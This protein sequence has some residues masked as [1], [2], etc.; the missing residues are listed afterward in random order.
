M[1]LMTPIKN[2]LAVLIVIGAVVWALDVLQFF[3]LSVYKEQYMS[4]TLGLTLAVIYLPAE[5]DA[6]TGRTFGWWASIFAAIAGFTT[7]GYLAVMY[8]VL[9]PTM[10]VKPMPAIVCGTILIPLLVEALRRVA[11]LTL[12]LILATFL[13]IGVFA[14]YLPGY[15]EGRQV[16]PG[17]LIS[18]LTLDPN[19]IL[20]LPLLVTSTIVVSFVLFGNILNA[21]GGGA[22]FTDLSLAA[23][24]RFRGGTAKI[25]IAASA[26]FGSV[27]GSAIANVASTGVITIPMMKKSGYSPSEASAIEASASTGGQLLP[28]VMGAVAFLMAEFLNVPYAEVALAALIPGLLYYTCLFIQVD[29]LAARKGITALKREDIPR[30]SLV[31][32]K[33]GHYIIPFAVLVTGL[34]KYNLEAER[35]VA[36]AT[37][38][39]LVLGAIRS[40]GPTRLTFRGVF[41]ALVTGGRT[42]ADIIVI[43]ASAGAIIGVLNITA[44][45]FGITLQL[46]SIGESSLLLLLITA[47]LL[48]IIM[49]MGLPTLGV[50]LLLATLTAPSLVE[51]GLT[52]ISAHMFI[53]FFGMMS[54]IT[55]PIA[56]AA[57]AAA[58]IGGA[59]PM[60]VGW[61]A[62][63]FSWPAF[64]L[65]FLFVY[66]PSLL[67][68]GEPWRIVVAVITAVLGI[69]LISS[70]FVGYAS[71]RLLGW[72]RV[73][74]VLA[75]ACFLL[76]DDA[77]TYGVWIN[78]GGVPLLLAL[79]LRLRMVREIPR[80]IADSNTANPI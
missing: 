35:A 75:G 22:F 47:A 77:A 13:I 23:M 40:Y 70:G 67:M 73:I 51:L 71:R 33:G 63:Q 78:L 29:L 27:S 41:H 46:V 34:F 66:S 36:Y 38:A 49:G 54:L 57:F 19:A 80:L 43:G 76:P 20:G 25:A 15:L 44:V 31:L 16:S 58:N 74:A 37:A 10:I 65:P 39:T 48:S 24:G 9:L 32:L 79:V 53:F 42:V 26:L 17:R 18:Y 8:P 62:V 30:A 1:N 50:Y 6:Q 52:P 56:V 4:F 5:T 14:H 12:C 64:I 2:A 55:P 59:P 69:A 7:C 72:E 3:S 61:K 45:S 21:A 28:P 11:G 68:M 60:K